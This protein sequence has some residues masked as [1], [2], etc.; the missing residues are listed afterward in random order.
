M[1]LQTAFQKLQYITL[2]GYLSVHGSLRLRWG[3]SGSPALLLVLILGA[4][5]ALPQAGVA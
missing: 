4:A 1:A 2:W 5:T 3:D